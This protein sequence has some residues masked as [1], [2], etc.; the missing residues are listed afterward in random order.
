MCATLRQEREEKEEE[1]Y[2]DSPFGLHE[3]YR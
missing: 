1:G 2:T 3:L